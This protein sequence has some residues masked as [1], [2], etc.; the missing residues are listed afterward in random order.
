MNIVAIFAGL[1]GDYLRV[2]LVFNVCIRFLLT[3]FSTGFFP[4]TTF[5]L[6]HH[7]NS[8]TGT[9]NILKFSSLLSFAPLDRQ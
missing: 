7:S 9:S 3:V 5:F 6:G 4:L 8:N 2:F 1:N